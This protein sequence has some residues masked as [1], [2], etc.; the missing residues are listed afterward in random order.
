VKAD[1]SIEGAVDTFDGSFLTFPATKMVTT[2][3]ECGD[4]YA[5][6]AKLATRDGQVTPSQCSSG[7]DDQRL[8]G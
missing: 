3:A 7:I 4:L 2:E 8:T 5:C 6:L 1:T